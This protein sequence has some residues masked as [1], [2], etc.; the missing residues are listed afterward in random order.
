[1]FTQLTLNNMEKLTIKNIKKIVGKVLKSGRAI[2]DA[3]D[4]NDSTFGPDVYYEFIVDEFGEN[5]CGK[6]TIVLHRKPGNQYRPNDYNVIDKYELFCMGLQ[7]YTNQYLTKLEIE[8][9]NKLIECIETVMD[10]TE[11]F[12][13]YKQSK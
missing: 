13:K 3:G 1:M 5:I 2:C 9:P 12:Y 8:N 4:Y 10:R 6:Q 11:S 7:S